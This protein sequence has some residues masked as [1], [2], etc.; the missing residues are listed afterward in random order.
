MGVCAMCHRTDVRYSAEHVIPE[1]LGGCY[2]RKQ[3][4][5]VDCNS[6][7]GE[8]VDAALVN[9]GLSKMFRFV[10]GLKGKAKNPPNPFVGEYRPL[11]DPDRRMKIRIGSGG[12]LI[13]YFIPAIRRD[14]LP[15]GRV[16]LTISVD[17]ADER[18][19]EPM[20]RKISKRLGGSAEGASAN[21]KK[22]VLSSEGGLTGQL[23]L[24]LRDFKIGLLKIAYEFAVDRIPEYVESDDAKQIASILREARFDEV[25]RYVNIGHG[26]DRGIMAPFSNFLG[27]EGVKH[28]LVLCSG[29]TGV[30]CFVH[31]HGLFSIGATLSTESVGDLVEIG[32]NDVEARSFRV[33][34]VEDIRVSTRYRPLLSFETEREADA[35]KEA[36]SAKDF[37]YES[38]GGRW[39]L[40]TCDGRYIGMDIEDV[41]ARLAPIRSEIVSGGLT[42]EF[43]LGEGIYL[44]LSGSGEIVR[45]LA[46]RAEHIWKKL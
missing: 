40:F 4:V 36:E 39:K 17:S 46:V 20:V 9:H 34:R 6:K 22:T 24:D 35:F 15:D 1:A 2:V 5:C 16:G 12:R 44:R 28:Y 26:F 30:H 41:V 45:V 25:E 38:D 42:E 37:A 23:A 14:D 29:V 27:Y 33:W 10:H 19:V 43:W 11:S 7:L 13:P 32:V 3:M 18:T 31:L 21:A 8:R